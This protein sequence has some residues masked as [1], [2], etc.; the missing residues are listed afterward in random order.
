MQDNLKIRKIDLSS[1][2]F[3]RHSQFKN[4]LMVLSLLA[5]LAI[6]LSGYLYY[7]YQKTQGELKKFKADALKTQKQEEASDVKKI[8]AEVSKFIDLPQDEQP[9]IA[10]ITN[11]EK[12]RDQDLFKKAKN[13]DKVLIYTKAKKAIIYDPQRGKIVEVSSVDLQAGIL[14]KGTRMVLRNGSDTPGLASKIAE[15]LKKDHPDLEIVSKDN[16]LRNDYEKTILV[17]LN[18][19]LKE[20]AINFAQSFN[21]T[22]SD[23]PKDESKPQNADLL[24]ILGQDQV[25]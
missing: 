18:E 19:V 24:L 7:Q 20:P 15:G 21:A 12:L 5:I 22:L 1:L 14:P 11:V 3:L 10:T 4:L 25:K 16:A 8:I 2:N 17:I 13:G 6:S 9:I 23:L